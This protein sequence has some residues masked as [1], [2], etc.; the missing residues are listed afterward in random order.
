M[1][2]TL[3]DEAKAALTAGRLGHLVTINPDGSPQVSVVWI[4]IENDEIVVGHLA[5]GRKLTNIERDPRV[6]LSVEADGRTDIGLTHHVIV[7]GTARIT[8]SGGREL[9]Q[10]LA[11]TYLG[12]DVKFPPFDDPPPGRVIRISVDKIGGVGPWAD[13]Q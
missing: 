8:E 2:A 7:Q 10:R 9:L 4:G 12:S 11:H 1:S 3:T 6:A 13:A 5:R